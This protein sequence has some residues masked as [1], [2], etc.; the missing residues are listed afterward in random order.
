MYLACTF[1]MCGFIKFERHDEKDL[2]IQNVPK[3]F[4]PGLISYSSAH[5]KDHIFDRVK[6]RGEKEKESQKKLGEDFQVCSRLQAASGH[7]CCV[8][9]G[10]FHRTRD[11]RK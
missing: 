2:K 8:H 9:D 6:T 10:V 11:T 1:Q 7:V 3:W 5:D 4:Q